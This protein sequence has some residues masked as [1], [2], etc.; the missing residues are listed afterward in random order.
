MSFLRPVVALTFAVSLL[1]ACGRQRP[2]DVG[3]SPEARMVAACTG[4]HGDPNR[5]ETNPLVNAAPPFTP[6]GATA[7]PGINAHLAHL[8]AGPIG[9]A[10][11]CKECHVV[12]TSPFHATGMPVKVLF[13]GADFAARNGAIPQFDKATISCA[14]NYCHGS[15]LNAGGSLLT[16]TWDGGPSQAACGTCHAAPPP[17]HAATSTDCSTCHPQTVKPDGTIDVAGGF[18]VNGSVEATGS[19]HPAGW[20]DPA[21]HGAAVNAQGMN[22]CKTCHGPALDGGTAGVSCSSCHTAGW[23]TNCTFCHGAPPA[24]HAATSTT[25]A[26][27]HPGTVNADGTINDAGGLHANGTLEVTGG[28]HPTGWSDPAVHGAEVNANGMNG[29]KTCHGP[30]LDGGTAGVSCS[31]CH[32]AGWQTNC[33]FCHSAPPSS[34][35]HSKHSGRSCGDC[36]P[37]YTKTSVNA[38]THD[39]GTRQVGNL[40]TAWNATTLKCT[41]CHGS[42]TW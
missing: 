36:H 31:S 29:C 18:H 13:T 1:A 40:V 24:S 4:C 22:G 41:G 7:S 11:A 16:P 8:R 42:D 3:V 6:S 27:C 32:T 5:V 15:T 25:C 2:V 26:S 38:A 21:Q 37:G 30:A 14:T 10:I 9:G 33:T 17:S 39:D 34:G 20:A 28:N 35:R 19:G 23:Q 12:P